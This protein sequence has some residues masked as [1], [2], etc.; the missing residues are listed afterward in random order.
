MSTLAHELAAPSGARDAARHDI[1]DSHTEDEAE[2]ED[3]ADNT[4]PSSNANEARRSSSPAPALSAADAEEKEARE[5]PLEATSRHSGGAGGDDARTPVPTALEF[6]TPVV[7]TAGAVHPAD[8]HRDSGSSADSGVAEVFSRS[9]AITVASLHASPALSAASPTSSPTAASGAF[10]TKKAV[11]KGIAALKS[12][13]EGGS[14]PLGVP[15]RSAS[16]P[17]SSKPAA[18]NARPVLPPSASTA[19]VVEEKQNSDADPVASADVKHEE[20]TVLILDEESA[21]QSIPE[22]TEK[23]PPSQGATSLLEPDETISNPFASGKDSPRGSNSYVDEEPQRFSSADSMQRRSR[24]LSTAPEAVENSG[25]APDTPGMNS[26]HFSVVSL[27]S[28]TASVAAGPASS[29]DGWAEGDGKRSTVMR[30]PSGLAAGQGEQPPG[31]YDF[32][33]ARLENQNAKLS[34]DE[35]AVRHSVDGA[36]KLRENFEKLREQDSKARHSRGESQIRALNGHLV[37]AEEAPTFSGQAAEVETGEAAGHWEGPPGEDLEDEA[38]DWEFWGTVMSNYQQ[39]ARTQPRDLSRAIQ[40]GIPAALRGMMWQLMSSSKDE[41]MEIIYAYYLKQSSPHEKAIRR[42]LNRTFPEQDYFQD[43][44]GIGQ[45]NLF[46]VVK[47]YSLYDPEVGYCQGMQFVVGPLLLNMPDE[48]AFS[49]LVRLM[50]SYDL[51]GH[52]TPNMP[53]LQLRLFQFDRLLEE[54]LPLLHMHLI[55]Q[56]V[57][58]S[59]YASQWFMTL[60]SYR[61]PLDLVYRILDSVFA[62]GVEALFRFALALMKKNEDALLKLN[63]D[64]AVA[65]LKQSLFDIYLKSEESVPT[66]PVAAESAEDG[67][68]TATTI[69]ADGVRSKRKK[70]YKTNEFVR[71]AFQ[72]KITPFM[73][74]SYASEFDEQVRAANAHRREV[75]ALRLVNRNLAARVK[76]LEDQLNSVNKEHVDLVKSVVMAKIAKEEMAEELVKYKMMYAEA[77]LQADQDN[78]QRGSMNTPQ[79]SAQGTLS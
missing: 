32:L 27:G 21:K 51:R 19:T 23:I 34:N 9:A 44:K 29:A 62:E 42:D 45:E 75:E 20:E 69:T 49:T 53:S 65:F 8:K 55:R 71:D 22:P 48:E 68:T 11:A 56:G 2:F 63:F 76:A 17:S 6:P 61:F 16:R 67:D 58:S 5:L 33:L 46:N 70:I 64:S 25:H 4:A 41:E 18:E 60:F 50:K 35:N 40:A 24:E 10:P 79:P 47:A 7:D 12:R 37:T 38:I 57:K 3:A 15:E 36:D 54:F 78:S 66:S 28:T 31:D 59:M 13:F 77:V 43:G 1:C 72:I 39:V 73:L 30:A 52:F 26:N 14:P 74:D